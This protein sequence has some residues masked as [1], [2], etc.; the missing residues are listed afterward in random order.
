[1]ND[2]PLTKNE[3][4]RAN[5]KRRKEQQEWWDRKIGAPIPLPAE[6]EAALGTNVRSNSLPKDQMEP[7]ERAPTY[8][9]DDGEYPSL[10]HEILKSLGKARGRNQTDDKEERIADLR[11][12][13]APY[14][15]R[16]GGTKKIAEAEA[17]RVETAPAE[18]TIRDY[19]AL[20]RKK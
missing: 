18:R 12:R 17:R 10:N 16:R 1:M 9:V 8:L 6:I 3:R 7:Y 14:W 4:R 15:G 13:Y 5:R 19:F 20:T 11:L 2:K